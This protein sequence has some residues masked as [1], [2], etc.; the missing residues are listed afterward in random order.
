M[1]YT[2]DEH[3]EALDKRNQNTKKVWIHDPQAHQ[4]GVFNGKLEH[5]VEANDKVLGAY[6]TLTEQIEQGNIMAS[7]GYEEN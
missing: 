3:Q 7:D 1:S 5:L 4:E 2:S 6:K